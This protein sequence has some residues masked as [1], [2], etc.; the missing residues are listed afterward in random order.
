MLC[1]AAASC[2]YRPTRSKLLIHRRPLRCAVVVQPAVACMLKKHVRSFFLLFF[3]S[4]SSLYFSSF[5]FS[6]L[7]DVLFIHV[8][9]CYLYKYFIYTC[10]FEAYVFSLYTC[11]LRIILAIHACLQRWC[12]APSFFF[13]SYL[14]SPYFLFLS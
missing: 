4:I 9:I 6:F 13:S 1:C 5:S 14:F 7:T 8:Q 10:M 2:G 3:I 12:S 11:M